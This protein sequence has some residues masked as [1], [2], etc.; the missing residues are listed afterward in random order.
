M[1]QPI[2]QFVEA[3]DPTTWD[4]ENLDM[5]V[6]GII[7]NSDDYVR[8]SLFAILRYVAQDLPTTPQSDGRWWRTIDGAPAMI[9][10]WLA[11]AANT[12]P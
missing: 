1:D 10:V 8:N 12:T 6:C 4:D 2:P 7:R 9:T 11:E 3:F 5:A